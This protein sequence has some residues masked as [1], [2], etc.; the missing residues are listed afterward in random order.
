MNK[1]RTIVEDSIEIL[2]DIGE[3]I[4]YLELTNLLQQKRK[5]SGKTPHLTVR[6][7]IGSDK[8]FIRIA[9]GTYALSEWSGY[10]KARF[11]K[12]IAYDILNNLNSPLPAEKLGEEILKERTFKGNP[13]QVAINAIR[14][15][16]RFIFKSDV[17]L[18]FL[19]KWKN[20]DNTSKPYETN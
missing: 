5:V 10:S 15:D 17:N 12:D 7:R 3:P 4:H 9:E 16:D 20:Q 13:K 8:R 19:A 14:F 11:A 2:K 6:S 18:I 1:S